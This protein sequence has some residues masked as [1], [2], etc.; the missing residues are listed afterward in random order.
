[1]AGWRKR[2]STEAD[3][4]YVAGPAGQI[5]PA[6]GGSLVESCGTKSGRLARFGRAAT[7]YWQLSLQA[8]KR[9]ITLDLPGHVPNTLAKDVK[10]GAGNCAGTNML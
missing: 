3:V 1:M 10:D 6:F 2:T 7:N 4:V 9:Q 5:V 8:L